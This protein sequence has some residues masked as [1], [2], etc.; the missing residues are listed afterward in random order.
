MIDNDQLPADIY[1]NLLWAFLT[2]L[3]FLAGCILW[4]GLAPIKTTIKVT[5]EILSERPS[6]V[7]QH[8]RGGRVGK[9]HV[10]QFDTVHLGQTLIEFDV[11]RE[12][13]KR[14]LLKEEHAVLIAERNVIEARLN[15]RALKS[16]HS[17]HAHIHA[18]YQQRE[19]VFQNRANISDQS[20]QAARTH[21]A[22]IQ[23]EAS[24]R[25][26]QLERLADRIAKTES[27]SA[28]GIASEVY[29]EQLVKEAGQAEIELAQIQANAVRL[30]DD[31]DKLHM[32]TAATKA[33]Y[34]E[35]LLTGHQRTSDR[36]RTVEKQILE[37]DQI[38]SRA[39]VK[40]SLSGKVAQLNFVREGLFVQPG[41]DIAVV[42]QDLQ[43]PR[44]NLHIPV[45]YVD[46]I[47][48]G[49]R[50]TLQITSLPQR[51]AL[52][53]DLTITGVAGEPVKSPEGVPAYFLAK[54]TIDTDTFETSMNRVGGKE[55]L[56]SGMPVAA[57]LFGDET[58]LWAYLTDP[59]HNMWRTA[60]ED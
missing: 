36:L 1:R 24:L 10:A 53:I 27:L 46:Q 45:H 40:A 34:L 48:V 41:E 4:A 52:P 18:L 17:S 15:G 51:N 23:K 26:A 49:Q 60:F 9:V 30:D 43:A 35:T 50:G 37:L 6:Y 5:G 55:I 7:V 3:V 31:I 44:V 22:S 39:D 20:V 54:A 29:L 32:E 42:S 25:E 16:D 59:L 21:R 57:N 19:A 12:L 38:I 2:V 14:Q 56:V 28:R 13:E 58:T 47:A 11:S 33:E 8:A